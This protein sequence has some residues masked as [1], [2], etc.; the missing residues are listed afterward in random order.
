MGNNI[1]KAGTFERCWLYFCQKTRAVWCGIDFA[2]IA[3]TEN[4][5]LVKFQSLGGGDLT[6]EDYKPNNKLIISHLKMNL[7]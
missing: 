2:Y 1:P 4:K 6:K 5:S 7:I 3:Y